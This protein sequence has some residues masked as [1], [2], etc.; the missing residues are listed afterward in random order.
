MACPSSRQKEGS[1]RDSERDKGRRGKKDQK[2]LR[3]SFMEAP[4]LI[5][6]KVKRKKIRKVSK[7]EEEEALVLHYF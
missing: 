3:T 2:L 5:L 4:W 7:E 6:S 1:W